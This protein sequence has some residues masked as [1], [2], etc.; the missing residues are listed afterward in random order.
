MQARS[1][2]LKKLRSWRVRP[3]R[4]L[5]I[6]RQVGTALRDATA[7]HQKSDRVAAA[8]ESTAP[9]QLRQQCSIGGASGGVLTVK[10]TSAAARFQLDRWLRGGGEAALRSG[11]VARVKVI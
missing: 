1:Q 10:A 11:G 5:T 7:K 9:A 6:A 4:D 8:W 2:S 3:D